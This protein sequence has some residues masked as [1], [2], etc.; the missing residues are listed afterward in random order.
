MTAQTAIVQNSAIHQYAS[1]FDALVAVLAAGLAL[2]PAIVKGTLFNWPADNDSMMRLVQI[3]D[4]LAGQAWFDYTQYRM[5]PEG[6]FAMHWSR[7]VDLPNAL[8]IYLVEAMSGSQQAGE[9]VAGIVWPALLFAV[10]AFAII[11]TARAFGGDQAA[12]PAALIGSWSLFSLGIYAPGSFDHHNIQ[13]TLCLLA[14]WALVAGPSWR[15]GLAAGAAT[16]LTLATGME[17][18]PF[19]AV[20][21]AFVALA[22]LLLGGAEAPRARGFGIGFATVSAAAFVAT[23]GPEHW[24]EVH[25]D[26]LSV[27]Q[28]SVASIGGVGLAAAAMTPATSRTLVGRAL[29]CGLLGAALVVLIGGL[30]PQCLS[31]PY[32]DLDPRL[33][34]IWLS[35]IA[36]AQ[37]V[38]KVATRNL[39]LFAKFYPIPVIALA[40]LAFRYR[41]AKGDKRAIVM[42][43]GFVL[44]AFVVSLWQIRGGNFAIA[45]STIPLA[46]WVGE[47][48]SAAYA[49]KSGRASL[50]MAVAWLVSFNIVWVLAGAGLQKATGL[51]NPANAS[52]SSSEKQLA[53]CYDEMAFA[54]LAALK[55]ANLLAISNIGP[56]I[57]KYTPHR[58]LAGPYHRN[59]SGNVATLDAFMMPLNQARRIIE[60]NS[61]DIVTYCPGNGESG[62]LAKRG[63]SG[64]LAALS[65][66]EPPAWLKRTTTAPDSPLILYRVIK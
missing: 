29:A 3:R 45:F 32:G 37:P 57:L 48:R 60:Q 44:S 36:E 4:L 11:R 47:L 30:F 10:S 53:G 15:H 17:T 19:V 24:F 34:E 6:G 46:A 52:D 42:L 63:T 8:L 49:N 65:R 28:L 33:A 51:R 27:A 31:G 43:G 23:V 26:A 39:V 7:I 25:C 22:F 14:L 41:R 12:F 61:I 62:Y 18:L 21:C 16:A 20:A 64:L 58:T 55:P 9:Q 54:E 1:R 35:A 56:A 13:I 38:T 2:I 66:D 40:V 5:G 59:N 50:A